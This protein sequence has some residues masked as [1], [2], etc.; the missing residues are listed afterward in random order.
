MPLTYLLVDFENVKRTADELRQLRGDHLRR[1]FF[2]IQRSR[3]YP[4]R[5]GRRT[6][7]ARAGTRGICHDVRRRRVNR[8]AATPKVAL[9]SRAAPS[10]T[11][12]KEGGLPMAITQAAGRRAR[13]VSPPTLAW[14]SE[15]RLVYQPSFLSACRWPS[16]ASAAGSWCGVASSGN[17]IEA[18]GTAHARSSRRFRASRLATSSW[19]SPTVQGANCAFVASRVRRANNRSGWIIW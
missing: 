19:R 16:P 11:S 12:V 6:A 5:A 14:A 13:A 9:G 15:I 8:L 3:I 10:L 7:R 2:D 4:S 18:R 17:R 1:I